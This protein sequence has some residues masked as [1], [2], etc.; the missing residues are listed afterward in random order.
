MQTI[1]IFNGKY[2]IVYV[3]YYNACMH[4]LMISMLLY[5]CMQYLNICLVVHLDPTISCLSLVFTVTVEPVTSVSAS[6]T[7]RQI[8]ATIKEQLESSAKVTW[9]KYCTAC[10]ITD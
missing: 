9:V 5:I 2:D 3:F 8:L 6:Y 4:V 10:L 7:I 1:G